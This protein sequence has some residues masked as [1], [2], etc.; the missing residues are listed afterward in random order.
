M[1][2]SA[3]L[4]SIARFEKTSEVWSRERHMLDHAQEARAPVQGNTRADLDA[5]RLLNLALVRSFEGR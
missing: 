2:S 3:S 1:S 5:D 4:R